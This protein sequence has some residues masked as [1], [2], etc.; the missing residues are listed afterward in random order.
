VRALSRKRAE[1]T[2]PSGVTWLRGD[3]ARPEP[4]LE[5]FLEGVD[6]LFHCAGEIRDPSRMAA[7]HVHGTRR[8]A[9]V[10]SGRIGAWVQLSSCGVYGPVREGTIDEDSPLN[11][12]GTY[13]RTRLA[14]ERV[15]SEAASD[16]GF[17]VSTLRPS[18]VFGS[19]MPNQSLRGLVRMVDRGMFFY[20]GEPDATANYVHVANVV[21]AL[22][23]C[24][25]EEAAGG[26]C[27]NLSQPSLLEVF[28]G[29]ICAHLGRPPVR[30]RLPLPLARWL[31]APSKIVPGYPLTQSRLDAL[32]S[33]AVYSADRL[34]RELGHTC[35]VGLGD[36]IG[37]FVRS[38]KGSVDSDAC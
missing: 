28:V 18:I 13:E 29:Q 10:A 35:R 30:T 17:V 7:L 23:L 14:A 12:V 38:M 25:F 26:R 2:D 37:A 34:A 20:V 4:G 36:G 11:P 32:T 8:L 31:V 16:K 22:L 15:V 21:D 19:D 5:A 33:R 1:G 9:R 27:Y 3:L 6:V 24:G